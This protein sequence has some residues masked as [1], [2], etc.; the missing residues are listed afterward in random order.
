VRVTH[1]SGVTTK[2]EKL[3]SCFLPALQ[4]PRLSQ[5]LT[6]AGYPLFRRHHETRKTSFVLSTHSSGATTN[7][8]KSTSC[9]LPTLQVP[10]M[11]RNRPRAGYP[12][13]RHD[14]ETRKTSF[15]FSTPFGGE[16]K[17]GKIDFVR[18]T[19]SSGTTSRLETSTSCG[20]PTLQVPRMS[21]NRPRAGY[22]LFRHDHE[23]RKTS[24]VFSTRSSGVTTKP[25]KLHSCF[26]PTLQ[27]SGLRQNRPGAG[28]PLFRHDLEARNIDLVF[29]THSS[30]V[31]T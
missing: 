10:R 21:R 7:V 13:F 12:L 11:S 20:L 23:T 16:K 26:L 25:E 2:P 31:T 28:Y 9:G 19:H 24:F 17:E 15:L 29:S 27:A 3:H 30:G 18:V 4:V 6:R 5:N 22:P 8:E 14:H 1:S